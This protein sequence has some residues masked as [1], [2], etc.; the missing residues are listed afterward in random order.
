MA[1]LAAQQQQQD[2]MLA[3]TAAVVQALLTGFGLAGDDGQA[4]SSGSHATSAAAAAASASA[5][6]T[7]AAPTAGV[8]V[9]GLRTSALLALL[10]AAPQC[11]PFPVRLELFRQMLQQD[12]VAVGARQCV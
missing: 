6:G 4:A 10:R 7:A 5:S 11:V 8:G 9:P 1:G 3:T 2:G 12:K